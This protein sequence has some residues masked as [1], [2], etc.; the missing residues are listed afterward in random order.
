MKAKVCQVKNNRRIKGLKFT[1]LYILW[2]TLKKNINIE[3]QE[4]L[5]RFAKGIK[6]EDEV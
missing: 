2:D 3:R 4:L 1:L 5:T 6:D